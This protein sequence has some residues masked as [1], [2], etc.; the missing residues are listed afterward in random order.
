MKMD[1]SMS[2]QFVNKRVLSNPIEAIVW[3]LGL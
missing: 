1:S 2:N 3:P